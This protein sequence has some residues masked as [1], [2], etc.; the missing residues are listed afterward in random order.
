LQFS[1]YVS[2]CSS[3]KD[4]L[5][6][7]LQ[8]NL[9][10]CNYILAT[11]LKVIALN[12]YFISFHC[13]NLW[14]CV[15]P[16]SQTVFSRRKFLSFVS[17]SKK[18]FQMHYC[19]WKDLNTKCINITRIFFLSFLLLMIPLMSIYIGNTD[20]KILKDSCIDYFYYTLFRPIKKNILHFLYFS[21]FEILKYVFEKHVIRQKKTE[22]KNRNIRK[23]M[24]RK[25]KEKRKK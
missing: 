24:K 10:S 23:K 21:I 18:G 6:C 4:P 15:T 25:K 12:V 19:A 17:I 7:L 8:V 5:P 22:V 1:F 3:C 14:S 20:V 2:I 13:C 16:F 9:L 11:V